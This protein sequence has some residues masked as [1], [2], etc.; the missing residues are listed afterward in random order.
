MKNLES[1]SRAFLRNRKPQTQSV[2]TPTALK[3]QTAN[4]KLS[5]A[6]NL[7]CELRLRYWLSSCFSSVA[8]S[9]SYKR[10][11]S[12]CELVCMSGLWI[13]L[14][15]HFCWFPLWRGST[16]SISFHFPVVGCAGWPFWFCAWS[17]SWEHRIRLCSA[18]GIF[19]CRCFWC[20][21]YFLML[22]FVTLFG[23]WIRWNLIRMWLLL[24]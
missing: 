11:S 1:L 7:R 22:L 10:W 24:H 15:H 3:P 2:P 14:F 19:H 12:T 4:P 23:L 21:C 6:W 13:W 8:R 5:S 16:S 17:I 20:F 18:H 9:R